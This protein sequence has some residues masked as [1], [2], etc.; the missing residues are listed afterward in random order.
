MLLAQRQTSRCMIE[1]RRLLLAMAM[2]ASFGLF[3]GGFMARCAGQMMFVE[4]LGSQRST[5]RLVAGTAVL[6]SVT[7]YTLE[8]EYLDVFLMPEGHQTAVLVIGLVRLYDRFFRIG[9]QYPHNVCWIRQNHRHRFCR[10]LRVTDGTLCFMAPF[11][12]AVQA[13]A[14]IRTL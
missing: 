3:L 8:T 2:G 10:L 4:G 13:L 7:A 14:M 1:G 5:L 11:S 9:M 6:F 12:M